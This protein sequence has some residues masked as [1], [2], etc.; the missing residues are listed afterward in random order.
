MNGSP[1]ARRMLSAWVPYAALAIALALTLLGT[2]YVM[3]TSHAQDAL[4]FRTAADETRHLIEARIQTY[5]EL[6]RAGAAFFAA[7]DSVTTDEFHAFVTHLRLAERYPGL[8]GMGYAAHVRSG[9]LR[10]IERQLAA[11]GRADAGVWPPGRRAEY[12]PILYL[13]PLDERNR[14]AIGYDMF[15]ERGRREAMERARDTG[16]ASASSKVTLIQEIDD[17]KQP[18]FLIYVPVYRKGAPTTTPEERRAALVGYLYSP[19]R[20]DDLLQGIVGP[21]T[22]SDRALDFRIFDGAKPTTAD[23]LHS[24]Y[25]PARADP[26]LSRVTYRIDMAGR[27]WTLEFVHLRPFASIRPWLAP[28]T[29]IGGLILSVALFGVT[30]AQFRAWETAALHAAELRASEEALRESE[31]R[32]RRL[33]VLER[34][35]RAVAQAADRAKD[36]FLATIS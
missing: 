14:A 13:E 15:T 26:D 22:N 4:E 31:T 1:L 11:L 2:S 7:S 6:L 10:Q 33:V 32:L 9:E 36:E 16:E 21:E 27:P 18:G 17:Q 30:L 24:S 12:T 29:F 5:I 23:L 19:F 28:L 3:R 20:A 8:Q 34:E 25:D 35:A